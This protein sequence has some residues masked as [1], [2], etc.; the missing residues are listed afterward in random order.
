MRLSIPKACMLIAALFVSTAPSM[1]S[2]KSYLCAISEVYECVEVTGCQR[3]SLETANLPAVMVLD[4]ENK[5]LKSAPLDQ[6]SRTADIDSLTTADDLILFHGVG[7][8]GPTPRTFSALI[9]MKTG[10]LTAGVSTPD[11][12]LAITGKCTGQP[13]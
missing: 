4:V 13:D 9:S 12:S 8:N 1:A 7:K 11:A 10:K 2:E 3:I 6:D 5:K